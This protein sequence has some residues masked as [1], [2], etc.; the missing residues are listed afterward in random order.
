MARPKKKDHP[1]VGR[2]GL[3]LEAALKAF[4]IDVKGRT[5]LDVGSSTGG[6]TDC[7]L[8]NGAE[9]VYAIDVG[10]GI[11]DWKLRK[12]PRVK[13]LE[14]TNVRYLKE[15]DLYG[16]GKKVD[17]RHSKIENGYG[18]ADLAVIDVSFI[19]LTIVLPVVWTLL[20]DKAEVI[21]LIKP[22]FEAKRGDVERGGIVRSEGVRSAV[23]ERIKA[24]AEG[25]GFTVKGL[26]ESPITGADGNVEYLIYLAK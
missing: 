1:Y 20:A 21:A 2:G 16:E 10:Y 6:F 3:K 9:K 18:K 4:S 24:K 19:S 26:I 17:S 11:L 25:I 14:R 7:L 23:L 12:D 15:E 8:Q 5:A 13:V 22:Q